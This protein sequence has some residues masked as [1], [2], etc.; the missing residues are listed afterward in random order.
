MSFA[1]DTRALFEDVSIDLPAHGSLA[2]VGPN[3]SGKTTLLSIVLGLRRPSAGTIF[4]DGVPYD[5][6]DLARLRRS[7]GVV[8]Q[9]APLLDATIREN[10]AYGCPAASADE[11]AGAAR[12]ATADEFIARLPAGYD[13]VVGDGGV[14]LSGGE[15]QRLA[16]ARA[17]LGR[18]PL[19]LLDEPTTH[20]DA[21]T[22]AALVANVRALPHRPTIVI[23]THDAALAASCD[24]TLGLGPAVAARVAV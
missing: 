2:I 22:A 14:R 18:P 11:I 8:L 9:H 12:A 4:A 16:L 3:G 23:T 15:R 13:T 20:L 10:L 5:E 7:T 24:E 17:L 21:A 6:L 19:L 1:H